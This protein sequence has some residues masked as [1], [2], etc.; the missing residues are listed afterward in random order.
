[1]LVVSD[2]FLSLNMINTLH[3]AWQVHNI[4]TLTNSDSQYYN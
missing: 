4:T 3:V 2:V 1:M